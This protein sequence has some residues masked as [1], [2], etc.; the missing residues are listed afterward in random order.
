M[1]IGV[2]TAVGVLSVL[3]LFNA[4]KLRDLGRYGYAGVFVLS[5]LANATIVVPAP[6]WLIP[7]VAG[8]TLDP[9]IVGIVVGTGQTIGELTG[10]LAG[11]S[12]RIIVE[13]RERYQRVSAYANRYGLVTFTVLSFIP[14]PLFDLAGILA[15]P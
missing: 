15:G 7:I 1:R 9:L 2:L 12:G 5:V 14:N 13:D 11:A 10:F 3:V 6:G 8:A 4:D